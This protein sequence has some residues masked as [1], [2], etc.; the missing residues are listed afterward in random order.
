MRGEGELG[1]TRLLLGLLRFSEPAHSP[2]VSCLSHPEVPSLCVWTDA[3]TAQL[4]AALAGTARLTWPGEAG[5]VRLL[6]R[7]SLSCVRAQFQAQRAL[8]FLFVPVVSVTVTRA[9]VVAG[10]RQAH[11][12]GAGCLHQEQT[13][14][15]LC[16]PDRS[17]YSGSDPWAAGLGWP[18]VPS[19]TYWNRLHVKM[20]QDC[21][22]Y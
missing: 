13:R 3:D 7:F 4:R 10:A 1:R 21:M 18:P 20:S 19:P 8:D 17:R 11:L 12:Y 2:V 22:Q 5:N 16:S 14:G 6:G 15:W 9:I